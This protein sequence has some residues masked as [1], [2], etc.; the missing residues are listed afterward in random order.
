[1]ELFLYL[2]LFYHLS[3]KPNKTKDGH[4][5]RTVRVS[6]KTGSINMSAW[7]AFGA[8]M[9]PGDIIRFSKGYDALLLIT[10]SHKSSNLFNS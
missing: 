8:Q 5:I 3:G 1:M 2:V 7:D 6:D 10:A 4:E 9:Q